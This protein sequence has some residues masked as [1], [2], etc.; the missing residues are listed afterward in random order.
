MHL[1]GVNYVPC[2]I[3]IQGSPP[4][5]TSATQVYKLHRLKATTR[6]STELTVM[7][8]HDCGDANAKVCPHRA[9]AL[10]GQHIYDCRSVACWTHANMCFYQM[11]NHVIDSRGATV[12]W[13][14]SAPVSVLVTDHNNRLQMLQLAVHLLHTVISTMYTCL[15]C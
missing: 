2:P 12:T 15:C 8:K 1:L 6:Q 9:D 11:A 14:W 4:L 5:N 3:W 13:Q 10:T 7:R